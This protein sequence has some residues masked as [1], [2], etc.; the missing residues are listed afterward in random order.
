MGAGLGHLLG[1]VGS[2]LGF[3]IGIP[4]GLS[5]AQ[6]DGLPGGARKRGYRGRCAV[7]LGEQGAREGATALHFT[8][9]EG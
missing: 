9:A 3:A 8:G 6:I 5:L 2:L 1:L 7:T 4:R